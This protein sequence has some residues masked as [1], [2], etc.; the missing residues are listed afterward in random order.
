MPLDVIRKRLQVQGPARVHYVI[1]D[2]PNYARKSS[3]L[4][5]G[6]KI[7]ME[8]GVLSLYKGLLPSL[9]KVAPASAVTFMVYNFTNR[10][11]LEYSVEPS[12]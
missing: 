1:D 12:K 11:L 3:I 5:I 8:E 2:I 6:R 4:Q 10:V 7:V 9:V